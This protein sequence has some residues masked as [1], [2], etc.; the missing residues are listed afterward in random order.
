MF[1]KFRWITEQE[2]A[3]K[4]PKWVAAA[5]WWS[6]AQ[7]SLRMAYGP[8]KITKIHEG[9]RRGVRLPLKPGDT[10]NGL[11]YAAIWPGPDWEA[12]KQRVDD[13]GLHDGF[14]VW[15]GDHIVLPMPWGIVTLKQEP[16][17]AWTASVPRPTPSTP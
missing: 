5:L 2:N 16:P 12:A 3:G 9:H 15:N 4:L 10:S 7:G 8:W 14:A 1:P 17:C 6:A 11:H 13:A